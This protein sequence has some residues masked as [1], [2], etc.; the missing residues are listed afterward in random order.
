MIC[1]GE[2]TSNIRFS[3]E[4]LRPVHNNMML[5]NALR[6][7][8]FASTLVEMQHDARIDSDPILTLHSYVCMIVN[9]LLTFFNDKFVHFTN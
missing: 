1:G 7:V 5:N 8:T 4:H 3:S 6:C 9:K 2:D